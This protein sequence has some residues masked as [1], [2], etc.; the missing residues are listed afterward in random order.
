MYKIETCLQIIQFILE[1]WAKDYNK[2]DI[3]ECLFYLNFLKNMYSLFFKYLNLLREYIF[4][5]LKI[6]FY[7]NLNSFL[8]TVFLIFIL[9]FYIM[10][11]L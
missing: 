2:K 4:I 8:L 5:F 3:F 9:K 11:S 6:I 7:L 10:L 1:F